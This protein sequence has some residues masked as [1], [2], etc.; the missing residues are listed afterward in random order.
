MLAG[1]DFEYL[2]PK[3]VIPQESIL[4]VGE[5]VRPQFKKSAA[6]GEDSKG[7]GFKGAAA[8]AAAGAG[9]AGA[10]ATIAKNGDE[11]AEEAAEESAQESD[12]DEEM[13]KGNL[14]ELE[15]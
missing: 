11:A 13:L 4:R 5:Q 3:G 2:N 6:G 7:N 1:P 12:D 15:G 14:A 8:V 10:A 9:A